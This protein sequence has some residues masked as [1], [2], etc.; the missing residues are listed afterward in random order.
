MHC[1]IILVS[2]LFNLTAA[3]DSTDG[4]ESHL[5]PL[6]NTSIEQPTVVSPAEDKLSLFDPSSPSVASDKARVLTAI[7]HLD[8]WSLVKTLRPLNKAQ[9]ALFSWHWMVETMSI[10]EPKIPTFISD[11]NAFEEFLS[12][13]VGIFDSDSGAKEPGGVIFDIVDKGAEAKWREPIQIIA[14]TVDKFGSPEH[15]PNNAWGIKRQR[16]V[17]LAY[18]W[19][20]MLQYWT[21]KQLEAYKQHDVEDSGSDKS[22]QKQLRESY[23][24]MNELLIRL[25]KIDGQLQ[26][27]KEARGEEENAGDNERVGLPWYFATKAQV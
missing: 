1:F 7:G 23:Y 10:E 16:A 8:Q 2:I 24:R 15:F 19:Y 27:A 14:E 3:D 5:T 11:I 17:K 21:A 13:T 4:T 20:A 9:R 6:V 25:Y 26:K 22:N 12:K 18:V